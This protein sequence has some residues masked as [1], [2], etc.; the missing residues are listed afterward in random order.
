MNKRQQQIAMAEVCGWIIAPYFKDR[1]EI[2]YA[3]SI[4]NASQGITLCS[5]LNDMGIFGEW[6]ILNAPL[7]CL[8]E[9]F[10]RTL[11]LWTDE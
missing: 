6:E 7:D 2:H 3:L 8:A 10:L 5:H 1:N 4:L 9:A 11:N